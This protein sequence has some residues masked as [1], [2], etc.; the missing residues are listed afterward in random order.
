MN[1][2]K[3][4]SIFLYSVLCIYLIYLIALIFLRPS[5]PVIK[6]ISSIYIIFLFLIILLIMGIS[7]NLRW[8]QI[9]N[10]FIGM[11]ALIGIISSIAH[12]SYLDPA[13]LILFIAALSAKI[14]AY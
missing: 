9:I 8:A 1:N 5:L 10:T 14:G 6:A 4:I 2:Y 3:K 11:F 7:K 12:R 13:D